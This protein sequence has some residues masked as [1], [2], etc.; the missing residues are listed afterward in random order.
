MV[1]IDEASQCDIPSALPLL[2]RAKRAV[3]IGD[4]N[5]LRHIATIS[6]STDVDEAAKAGVGKGAFLYS[7]RS[8]FDLAQR[9]VGNRPGNL[10]LNE[11]YR[12]DS[13]IISFSNHVFYRDSL[14]IRT[15]LTQ[16]GFSRQ[17]LNALEH[18]STFNVS[19][20]MRQ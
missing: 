20:T 15:D 13:R 11:H 8:L 2:Y 9:S 18:A 16:N 7:E 17:F 1:I 3:I 6:E 19:W 5:Q 14:L 4:P 12:S 10:L